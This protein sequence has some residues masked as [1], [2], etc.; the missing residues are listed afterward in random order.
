M[1]RRIV[2]TIEALRGAGW[3]VETADAPIPLPAAIAQ[4]YPDLP[5]LAREWATRVKS[6]ASADEGC[7]VPGAEDYGGDPDDDQ[8]FRWDEFERMMTE[9]DGAD[10]GDAAAVTAFWDR[11][12]PILLYVA[13][14]YE[15]VALDMDPASPDFGR[16]M[17]GYLVDYDAP[18][19]IAE[20]FA[21]F[22]DKLRD[23]AA[24]PATG[25]A[26]E[27]NYLVLL[28]HP[29]I[30]EDRPQPE[31]FWDRLRARLFRR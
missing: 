17:H 31:G 6:C 23:A 1:D 2:A 29:E 27:H 15:Y 24:S 3:T 11:H 8:S 26:A 20:D 12:F 10:Y 21:G 9:P 14:D 25:S 13:G 16:A 5:P 4:R 19:A 18:F 30:E 7:W 22:L 28:V